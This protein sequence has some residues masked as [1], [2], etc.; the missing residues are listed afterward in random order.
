MTDDRLSEDE[1]LNDLR[2]ELSVEPSADFAA[3]VR[4]GMTERA[5]RRGFPLWWPVGLSAIAVTVIAVAF[6]WHRSHGHT[7]LEAP[8]TVLS[9]PVLSASQTAAVSSTST[10]QPG[11][12][13][14]VVAQATRPSAAAPVALADFSGSKDAEVLVPPD[15]AMA[16]RQWL[17]VLRQD[18]IAAE[19][20]GGPVT[21][22]EGLL[23]SPKAIEIPVLPEIPLI[24]IEPLVPVQSAPGGGR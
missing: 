23:V 10:K 2:R 12:V 6:V 3:R 20:K 1:L 24:K 17:Q 21:D 5:E 7:S 19:T 22:A 11:A 16:L 8:A 15:Q 18:H 14:S 4:R 13:R 9:P